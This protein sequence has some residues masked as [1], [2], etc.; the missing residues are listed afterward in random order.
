V[1]AER[2]VQEVVDALPVPGGDVTSRE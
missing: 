2:I 1:N